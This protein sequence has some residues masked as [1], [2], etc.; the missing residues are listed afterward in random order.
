MATVL[1]YFMLKITISFCFVILVFLQAC[2]ENNASQEEAI[3]QIYDVE[4]AFNDLAAEEGLQVAF[5]T[6][7]DDDAALNRGGRI[8]QGKDAIYKFYEG[9]SSDITLSWKPDFVEV[10]ESL[11]MAYTYGGYTLTRPDS[12]GNPI[13]SSGIFHTV[14]K[15]QA[16]GSWKYV[17]D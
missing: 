5:S 16:D 7:A 17:Y 4:K 1:N 10:S 9:R 11:D 3:Q 14:W 13:S 8:I 12:T 2:V 6:F 15:K